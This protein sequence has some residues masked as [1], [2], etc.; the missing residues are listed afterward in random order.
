MIYI[1]TNHEI[2]TVVTNGNEDKAADFIG[3]HIHEIAND[4]C[5]PAGLEWEKS[6]N[7]RD[8]RG[9]R[10][11]QYHERYRLVAYTDERE[12]DVAETL[13]DTIDSAL[14]PPPPLTLRELK[15]ALHHELDSFSDEEIGCGVTIAVRDDN[16]GCEYGLHTDSMESAEEA[17]DAIDNANQKFDL[18]LT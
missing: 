9:G 2:I 6:S 12:R 4:A 13:A 10:H 11:D 14:E 8:W 18:I 16:E 1:C 3:L 15:D 17:I 7:F 5:D